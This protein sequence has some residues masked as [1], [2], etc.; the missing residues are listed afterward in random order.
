MTLYTMNL[1]TDMW[2]SI[3]VDA[4]LTKDEA[5]TAFQELYNNVVLQDSHSI[6]HTF[7]LYHRMYRVVRWY[8]KV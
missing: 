2:E 3:N 7:R 6:Y 4:Y 1:K 5:G 8:F